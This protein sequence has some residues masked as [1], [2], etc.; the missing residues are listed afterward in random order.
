MIYH[1]NSIEFLERTYNAKHSRN[2]EGPN[3]WSWY[4]Q[5]DVFHWSNKNFQ[6]NVHVAFDLSDF[7]GHNLSFVTIDISL[8]TVHLP[9]QISLR[10]K[11]KFV[12]S[13]KETTH[14]V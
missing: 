12:L 1:Y 4:R 5:S 6:T 3:A 11:I 8:Q 14:N 7:D 13:S 9:A 10:F 2:S